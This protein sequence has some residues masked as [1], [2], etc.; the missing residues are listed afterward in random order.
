[1]CGDV[2]RYGGLGVAELLAEAGLTQSAPVLLVAP[3]GRGLSA[4]D[5]WVAGGVIGSLWWVLVGVELL[6]VNCVVG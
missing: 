2:G 3:A 5:A 1:M 6:G 4:F